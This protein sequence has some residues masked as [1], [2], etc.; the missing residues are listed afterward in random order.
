MHR[1]IQTKRKPLEANGSKGLFIKELFY[2]Q[3]R[4]LPPGVYPEGITLAPLE[5]IMMALFL[6]ITIH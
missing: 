3:P 6:S 2:V 5:F 1:N 4:G